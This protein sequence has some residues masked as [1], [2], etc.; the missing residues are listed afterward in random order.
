M[1]EGAQNDMAKKGKELDDNGRAREI[2]GDENEEWKV[3]P[4]FASFSLRLP[5]LSLMVAE[6]A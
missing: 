2:A 4:L 3:W 1:S 6:E 5:F